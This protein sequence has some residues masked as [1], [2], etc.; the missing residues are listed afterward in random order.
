MPSHKSDPL[1]EM[2]SRISDLYVILEDFRYEVSEEN[3]IKLIHLLQ[4]LRAAVNSAE[5]YLGAG[6]A[7]ITASDASSIPPKAFAVPPY[8][9]PLVIGDVYTRNDLRELFDIRD[10]TLNNGVFRVKGTDEIWLFVTENKPVDRE[11]YVDKLSG[12]LL[13]WQGQKLGRT[14]PLI[15]GHRQNCDLLL[16]FYRTAK[17][18]FEG[19]GFV[20]EG[21]F[22]YVSHS[23]SSPTS[24]V[25]RRQAA[26]L[27]FT[28]RSGPRYALQLHRYWPATL[29]PAASSTFRA[30]ASVS[31][32]TSCSHR[33]I[34]IQPSRRSA[35]VTS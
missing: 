33:R 14:D 3:R 4:D 1:D 12:D 8:A 11:Q 9:G 23:G 22:E 28:V 34:T 26:R 18:Q 15:I 5:E 16:L 10:M 21:P 25:L 24:F 17:Y 13:Y 20:F 6:T 31:A 32:S 29:L 35:S 30:A 2:A 19:A 27:R 7:S